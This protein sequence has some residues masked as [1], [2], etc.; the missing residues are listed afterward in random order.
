MILCLSFTVNIRAFPGYEG[1][2][3][4]AHGIGEIKANYDSQAQIQ[5]DGTPNENFW[6][7]HSNDKVTVP[8]STA[9]T[10]VPGYIVYLNLTF[11]YNDDFMYILCMWND[12]TI[13]S[14][15]FYDGI[16]FCW[17]I[18]V[19]NFTADYSSGMTTINMGG[20]EVDSWNWRCDEIVGTG[21]PDYCEDAYFNDVVGITP[22]EDQNVEMAYTVV[23]NETYTLEI[24]RAL[25]TNDQHDIQFKK[26]GGLYKFNL[27][28]MNDNMDEGHAISWTWA[29]NMGF[30]KSEFPFE[31]IL[32]ISSVCV[33]GVIAIISGVVYK[34]KRNG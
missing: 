26:N 30:L 12:T 32:I 31:T 28:I 34:K 11:V 6:I 21:V 1:S 17:N 29:L 9:T 27:A 7:N 22:Y 14:L 5:L 24:K 23:E 16:F 8:L 3:E 15:E 4:D 13:P 10:V 33:V 18:N 2:C 19:P 25:K 20:G